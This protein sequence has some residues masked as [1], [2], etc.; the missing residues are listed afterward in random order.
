[1]TS[2]RIFLSY[3]HDD[4][5]ALVLRIKT[6]LENRGH[7]VWIDKSEIKFGDDWRRAITDGIVS[8]N[9]VLSFLSKHSTRDPGVCLDEIGIAIGVKG[10]NIQTILLESEMEVKPPASIS[11]I[12]WLDM[13]DW[14]EQCAAGETVWE[15]WYQAKLADIV[16]VVE[17]EESRRFAGEIETLKG[18]LTP[19]AS[20]SRIAALLRKGF[21][22]RKWIIDAI[23]QWRN[24]AD[25]GSRLFWITGDPGVGKSAFAA[26]LTHFGRDRVIA[27][28]FVEW[29]KM[30]HRHADRVVRSIAFQLAT[31]LPDYRKLLLTLPEIAEL[32]RKDQAELF[33]YLLTNPLRSVIQG[34]RDRY[35]IVIDAL[36]E[37]DEAG[38]NSLVEILARHTPRLPDWIGLIVT[39]RP[40]SA[41]KT[42]LQGLKPFVLDTR[43]E[44]NRDDLRDY[45]RHEL[46]PQLQDRTDAAAL[47]EEILEKSEGVFLY[48]ERFCLDVRYNHLSLDQPE[49]FP[50]GLGGIFY[51]W[52][53][54]QFRDMETFR[55]D[56]RPALRAILTAREPLPVEILQRLFSWQDEE[57]RDFTRTL[58]ALFPVTIQTG[59]EI[60]K[61]YHKSLAD[62]LTDQAKAAMYFVSVKEGHRLLADYGWK[63][64]ERGV[65]EMSLYSVRHL[66]S[67]LVACE[68]NVDLENLLLAPEFGKRKCDLGLIHELVHDYGLVSQSHFSLIGQALQL[69]AY[70]IANDPNQ[71]LGQLVGRLADTDNNIIREFL[72]RLR[73][74]NKRTILLPRQATLQHPESGIVNQWK[75]ADTASVCRLV[76]SDD[77]KLIAI[78]TQNEVAFWRI[79]DGTPVVSDEA[80]SSFHRIDWNFW[81]SELPKAVFDDI[82]MD[83]TWVNLTPPGPVRVKC[84]IQRTTN[85]QRTNPSYSGG[86][87]LVTN[88]VGDNE[89]GLERSGPY[90]TTFLLSG[91]TAPA[92][93]LD[94]KTI[95]CGGVRGQVKM[96]DLESRS[97]TFDGFLGNAT[98]AAIASCP[99]SGLLAYLTI[100]GKIGVGRA[101]NS[102][103]SDSRLAHIGSRPEALWIS[104][105]GSLVIVGDVAGKLSVLDT[106][107]GAVVYLGL[108]S[109]SLMRRFDVTSDFKYAVCQG[110]GAD[111]YDGI[112]IVVHDLERR[113]GSGRM[114]PQSRNGV[115]SHTFS[116]IT[117]PRCS[118]R[119]LNS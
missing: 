103:K 62:W 73:A 26:H 1:M 44:A 21:V 55:K 83:Y 100:D 13:H 88:E 43:S 77:G 54:R 58:G 68:R 47:V 89:F 108:I 37:A 91:M 39:S 117:D 106:C 94:A 66:P 110:A 78:V 50:Q 102:D 11:Y 8:S 40:E 93:S 70:V 81:R 63:E 22:G 25:Q 2:L 49:Q 76:V 17:S 97:L 85:Q 6:D 30:D 15:K 34:G 101:R 38:H 10:G 114:N 3:G 74:A 29:D 104:D 24:A 87:S 28:Q 80:Q 107:S 86:V 84:K 16:G 9:R 35:L 109:D 7:D 115:I 23:E 19:I 46:A 59:H 5:E 72:E 67:H 32:D 119:M 31:R 52:F 4:N 116:G 42:P 64:F 48:I 12:Q 118:S 99:Q 105:D 51:Q 33:D 113:G 14:T 18:Y 95:I 41:V 56:V 112:F 90:G 82:Q 60:I 20:D 71:F 75:I 111:L 36:D 53:Q 79:A 92:I 27:A 96:W 61:P 65:S 57:L 45:L 69:S 98:I